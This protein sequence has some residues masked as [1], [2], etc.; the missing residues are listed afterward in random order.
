MIKRIVL[1]ILFLTASVTS[2]S[3][4]I[5]SE[6]INAFRT[7]NAVLLAG[8]FNQTIEFNLLDK[9][10]VYSKVQAEIILRDFF[11]NNPPAQ[12]TI[13]HQ[14]GKESSRY[15]VGVLTSE[16]N[17]KFRITFLVKT[18]DNKIYIHQLR[19]EYENA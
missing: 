14:G 6:I 19:I 13:L 3:T 18:I 11:L 12:F 15:A 1:S 10:N 2:F 16:N 17:T 9:E 8:Y 5:P 4:E 7:G